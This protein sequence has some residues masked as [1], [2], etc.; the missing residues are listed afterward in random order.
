MLDSLQDPPVYAPFDHA[1]NVEDIAYA[2]EVSSIK[3]FNCFTEL[4]VNFC[5]LRLLEIVAPEEVVF[6]W[7]WLVNHRQ[8]PVQLQVEVMNFVQLG[9]ELLHEALV[10][11]HIS[12]VLLSSLSDCLWFQK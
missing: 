2:G 11:N 8:R 4:G 7:S 12:V 3:I 9:H 10:E 5:H 6:P 1:E